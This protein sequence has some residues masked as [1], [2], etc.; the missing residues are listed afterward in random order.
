[1]IGNGFMFA[2]KSTADF[3][4]LVEHYSTQYTPKRKRTSVSVPGRN[5]A[6]HYDEG[7]FDNY[8]QSYSCGF[9]GGR[10]TAE[11]AHEIKQWLFYSGKYQRLED[12]YDP[13]HFRMASFA[14]PLDIENQ[15][16]R[17]GKCTV[18]FDC[19][20]QYYL[21]S[22]EFPVEIDAPEILHNLY[23]DSDPLICVYGN[24]DCDLTVG[25]VT[26]K[27]FGL[28]GSITLDCEMKN[29]YRMTDGMM[30]NQNA[31]IFAMEFP[32][33]LH[34]DNPIS[35][36]GGIERLEIIPRWWEL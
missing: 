32:K 23:F 18:K 24:G 8:Q 6:L 19:A 10:T 11:T 16:N 21:K 15:L 22:G 4:M 14:G 1:M 17:I 12:A 29:A 33:L 2:G 9:L 27:L 13:Y 30:E 35:W 31:N 34:G 26:V 36:S 3:G 7:A 20:P 5:G 25:G 28:Q